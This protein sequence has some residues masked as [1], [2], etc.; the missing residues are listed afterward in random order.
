MGWELVELLDDFG[1]LWLEL[2]EAY[3]SKEAALKAPQ[4]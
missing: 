4:I 2:D 3:Q 1:D